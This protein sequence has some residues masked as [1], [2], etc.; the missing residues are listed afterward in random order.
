[1]KYSRL[2]KRYKSTRKELEDSITL[3][4]TSKKEFKKLLAIHISIIK[5]QQKNIRELQA[6]ELPY[7]LGTGS[8]TK[9]SKSL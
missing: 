9:R 3:L 1:V 6:N 4:L 7:W 8:R 2:L 5:K